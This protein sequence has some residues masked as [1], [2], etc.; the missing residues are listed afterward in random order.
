[1]DINPFK[2]HNYFLK[3][4]N[5]N[6]FFTLGPCVDDAMDA[7][8]PLISL[9]TIIKILVNFGPLV[10]F[11]TSDLNTRFLYIQSSRKYLFVYVVNADT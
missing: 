9:R 2:K 8:L 4:N 5:N 7:S 10:T 1:M 3:V 6:N 11:F